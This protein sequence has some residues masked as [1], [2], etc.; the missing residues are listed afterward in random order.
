MLSDSPPAVC[1][2]RARLK[3]PSESSG[4]EKMTGCY[5]HPREGNALPRRYSKSESC[6]RPSA[7]DVIVY[8]PPSPLLSTAQY[9]SG[10]TGVKNNL[11][12]EQTQTLPGEEISDMN[13][14]L[15]RRAKRISVVCRVYV[16]DISIQC[17]VSKFS[18][19]GGLCIW[20]SC[21]FQQ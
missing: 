1:V 14:L 19:N 4:D 17:F 11:S 3:F 16:S 18:E 5:K 9:F 20:R 2:M 12:S 15:S 10:L 21:F 6:K 8:P 7:I 13:K